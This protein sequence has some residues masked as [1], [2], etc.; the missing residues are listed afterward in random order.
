VVEKG[1]GGLEQ[2]TLGGVGGGVHRQ[3]Q[4][5]GRGGVSIDLVDLTLL[6]PPDH[7]HCHC[8]M[9]VSTGQELGAGW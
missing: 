5:K 2:V 9:A 1:G 6:S 7:C 3:Q 4:E 8:P